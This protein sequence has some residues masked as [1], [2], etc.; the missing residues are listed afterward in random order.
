MTNL[1]SIQMYSRKTDEMVIN[2]EERTL[3]IVLEGR[4]PIYSVTF[5]YG[6]SNG[7]DAADTKG[8]TGGTV[9]FGY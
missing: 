8:T 4:I 1:C 2:D 6:T 3:K 7:G 9:K 5:L